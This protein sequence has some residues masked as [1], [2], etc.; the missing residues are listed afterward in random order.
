MPTYRFDCQQCGENQLE[1]FPWQTRPDIVQCRQC[2][3]QA[4]YVFSCPAI[5]LDIKR[6]GIYSQQL[7]MHVDSRSDIAREVRRRGWGCDDLGI[8]PRERENDP[9]PYQVADHIVKEH[10]DQIEHDEW[11]G[12]MPTKVKQDKFHELKKT[13]SGGVK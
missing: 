2:G 8:K 12:R 4:D 13:L 5:R 10:V 11:E 7:G 9:G 6:G 3:G 1:L